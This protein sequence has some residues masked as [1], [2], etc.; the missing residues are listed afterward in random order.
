MGRSSRYSP[1]VRE[2]AVRMVWEHG[3]DHLSEWAAIEAIALTLGCT[4]ET[5]RRSRVVTETRWGARQSLHPFRMAPRLGRDWLSEWKRG[6][7]DSRHTRSDGNVRK[8]A[9]DRKL[10]RLRPFPRT[11]VWESSW[12]GPF[13]WSTRQVDRLLRVRADSM[14][15]P[16]TVH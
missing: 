3:A 9:S 13:V 15:R 10:A 8:T 6:A 16:P 1:G 14:A 11:P 4:S 2:R 12:W 5:L 7:S